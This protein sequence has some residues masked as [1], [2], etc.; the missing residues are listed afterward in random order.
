MRNNTLFGK[1]I[2]IWHIT[3]NHNI[4][5]YLWYINWFQLQHSVL[6]IMV[7]HHLKWSVIRCCQY[8]K[9]SHYYSQTTCCTFI[10]CS[11]K[12]NKTFFLP[13]KGA[14]FH[15]LGALFTIGNNMFFQNEYILRTLKISCMLY[16]RQW[17]QITFSF[18]A[19]IKIIVQIDR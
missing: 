15:T 19:F 13:L 10:Q 17:Q 2:I 8:N 4:S 16:L 11:P 5:V 7:L 6:Y 9:Y 1:V 18:M 3:N 14:F 12:S